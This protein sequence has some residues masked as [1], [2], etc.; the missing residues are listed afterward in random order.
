MSEL[1]LATVTARKAVVEK[2]NFV[3]T[4]KPPK[5][6]Y[7]KS[8]IELFSLMPQNGGKIN[9]TELVEARIKQYNWDIAN[10]RNALAVTMDSLI[11]KIELNREQF[12]LRKSKKHL[13]PYPIEF[14]LERLRIR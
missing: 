2:P 13:G 8:E 5:M 14:W 1:A 12:R 6:N 9:S 3:L 10:P 11:G 7:S 4:K